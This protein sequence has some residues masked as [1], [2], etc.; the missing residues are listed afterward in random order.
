MDRV[1]LHSTTEVI[2]LFSKCACLALLTVSHLGNIPG[3][4]SQV[5]RLPDLGFGF[6]IG[7]NDNQIGHL[8]REVV[9]Y[10]IL[11]SI[12][13]LEPIDWEERSITSQI[14]KKPLPTMVIA[15]RRPAPLTESLTWKYFDKG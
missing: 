8:I 3:F 7:F 10:R 14:R 13:G 6:F 15:E 11:D 2:T 5:I 1:R 4:G 12:L 9:V